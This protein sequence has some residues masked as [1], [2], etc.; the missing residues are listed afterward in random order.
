M[1]AI[2]T[3]QYCICNYIIN[4]HS[5]EFCF[6]NPFIILWNCI[7]FIGIYYCKEYKIMHNLT[8]LIKESLGIYIVHPILI[9]IFKSMNLWNE[10][11]WFINFII[12][13]VLSFFITKILLKIPY[14][15]KLCTL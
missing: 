15:N 12:L 6:S 10:Y 14:I 2:S 7:L 5:P 9:E 1:I 3:L 11:Y 8:F 4:L 13:L